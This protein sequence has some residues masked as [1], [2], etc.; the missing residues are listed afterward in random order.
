MHALL[1]EVEAYLVATGMGASTFGKR[2]LNDGHAVRRMR[3]GRPI[4]SRNMSLIR[5]FMAENPP[6]PITEKSN[7][8]A[9]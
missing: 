7:E 3:E 2:T 9:A 5:R 1:A 6:P 8:A 4:T